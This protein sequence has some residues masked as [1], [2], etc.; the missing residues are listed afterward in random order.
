MLHWQDVRYA[1][2]LL[3]RSP[4]FT[5]LTVV[6]LGGGLGLAIFTFS[7]L[8]TA[9]LRP[10]PVSGGDRIVRVQERSGRALDAATVAAARPQ[11]TAL[12]DVGAFAGRDLV[13]GEGEGRRMLDAVAA[14]WR[15]FDFT[16]TPAAL[17]RGFRL[18]DQARGAEPVVVL[19]HRAWQVLFGADSSIVGRT[20]AMNGVATR[21]IGVMPPGYGFPAAASAWVPL[22]ADVM[23]AGAVAGRHAVGIYARL[24]PGA[25][26]RAAE[27]ELDVLLARAWRGRTPDAD[28][29]GPATGPPRAAVR[30]FPMAQ[31][32]D[33]APLVL[34]VLN[35]LA[36]LILLL[37]CINVVN[38][39]LARANERVR[40]TA[41]RLAL[42]AP[43]GR[44][45]A[46]CLWESVLLCLAG[47]A[48][49]TG[50]AAWG[51]SAINAWTH[52]RLEGNLTFW[53]VWGP[54]R[55]TFLAAGAFVTVTIAALGG[56]VAARAANT[57]IGSVLGDGG[58]RGGGRRMGRV[59][60]AL[61]VTQV[62]VV[63]VLMF[64]G[65]MAGVV[66]HRVVTIDPG[67]DTRALLGARVA[68]SPERHPTRE[69]RAAFYA[70]VAAA[71]ARAPEV[72]RVLV[73]AALGDVTGAS[74]EVEVAAGPGAAPRPRAWVVGVEGAVAT[75]GVAPRAGR[76]LDAS[77]RAGGAPVA[78]VSRAFAERQWPGR[79]AVGQRVRLAAVEPEG[80]WRTVVGVVSDVPYG[81]ELSRDR[82]AVAV[83]VPL[84]QV[85]AAGA[86]IL[87]RHRGNPAAAQAALHRVVA[88]ADPLQQ[89]P[90]VAT[91]DEMREKTALIARS[92]ARLF[93][94]CFA[95]ALVLAV[96]GTYG[97]MARAIGQRTR[98]LGVRRALG[99]TDGVLLRALLGQGARQLGV[100]ALV[101]LPVMLLV[102]AGFA[103]FL[104]IGAWLPV[105]A[106][107]LVAATIVAVV[108]A[109]TYVPTRAALRITPRDA[110]WRD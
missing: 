76:V 62:A 3:R 13:V 46:Q 12:V 38:L 33:E 58:A 42:G 19:G 22:E 110:L 69:E 91:F 18:D 82:S 88:D 16:R 52:A 65:T 27:R 6:V 30:S 39:L 70:A 7:F 75:I 103:H 63:S 2:R 25:T 8:H 80:P 14:E 85:D 89:P 11:L 50:V 23:G 32:G 54:D 20:V 9:M 93:G 72:D 106:A 73:R 84:G 97:L 47:G 21:V 1:L 66:A 67:Y 15:I 26:A 24:A 99:A 60:R 17:G 68:P 61:V 71:L 56:G 90:A 86:T 48:V 43:R 100:G 107:G 31:I 55:T 95:F 10:I 105:V 34:T 87:V 37:A 92:V 64:F 28:A 44:L 49:A 5:L 41:V 40:E 77:D 83:Y 4:L 109:A 36:V 51:L 35:L 74:G 79:S 101:A 96:S 78:V 108:L 59:N 29:R 57:A 102:G 98:E 45:V 104:P 81:N 94:A 53:W